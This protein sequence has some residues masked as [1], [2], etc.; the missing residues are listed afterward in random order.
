MAQDGGEGGGGGGGESCGLQKKKFQFFFFFF[1]FK[2]ISISISICMLR[3]NCPTQHAPGT[4][5]MLPHKHTYFDVG[6]RGF[7]V[8]GGARAGYAR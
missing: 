7:V 5:A 4:R 1:F 6:A 3:G 8:R 2:N